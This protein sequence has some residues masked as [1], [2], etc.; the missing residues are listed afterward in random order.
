MEKAETII[1]RIHDHCPVEVLIQAPEIVLV[2]RSW[3]L[4]GNRFDP[5]SRRRDPESER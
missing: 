3:D 4:A 1:I 2:I 5:G